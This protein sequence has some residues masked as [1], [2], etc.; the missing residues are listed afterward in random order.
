MST[1]D[2]M[3]YFIPSLIEETHCDLSSS[4]YGVNRAPFCEISTVERDSSKSFI[5]TKNLF[6][7]ISVR[8]TN[9]D[10]RDVG[11]YEPEVGD[12]IA[13]TDIKPKTVHDLDRPKRNYH[14]AYVHRSKESTDKISILSSKCFGM[15][16]ESSLRLRSNKA[17]KLYAVYLLNLTTNIRVWKALNSEL[18]GANMSMIKKVLQADSKVRITKL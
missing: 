6:Y 2:Y 12:L 14:I 17:P 13:F 4:L 3:S 10:V 1:K 5:P 7:Q 11:T 15:E 9:D 8:R 16:I 18:E